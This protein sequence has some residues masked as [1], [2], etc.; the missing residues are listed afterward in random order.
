M[1]FSQKM[2]TQSMRYI[3]SIFLGLYLSVLPAQSPLITQD[4]LA[5][6]QWVDSVYNALS[7]KQ[8]VGQLFMVQAFSEEKNLQKAK[9]YFYLK[10]SE[11]FGTMILDIRFSVENFKHTICSHHPH[12]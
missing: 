6:K 7:L 10:I 1:V 8:K 11:G 9:F 2:K 4:S 5:Q 12:L 3:L